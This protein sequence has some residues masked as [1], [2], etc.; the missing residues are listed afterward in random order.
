[1]RNGGP[2]RAPAQVPVTIL[3]F[4]ASGQGGVART[5]LN[6]ASHLADSHPVRIVSLYGGPAGQGY[7]VDPRV[8]LTTL[9]GSQRALGPLAA[10][11]QR[12]PS[13]L[14]PKP[15][16]RRFSRLTDR[17]L[18]RSLAR[19]EPGLLIS[20]RPSLHLAAVQ[21]APR[22]V[23]IIGQ[24]HKNFPVRF[25][26]RRQEQ[27]LRA[28]VP[29]LDAYVVLTRADAQ[30][31]RR[32]MPE[33]GRQHTTLAVIGNALPWSVPAAAA[34]LDTKVIVAAGRLE[35]VKGFDRL[36]RAFALVA[37]DRPDW[38][39]HIYGEGGQRGKLEAL[40]QRLELQAQIRL[41]GH[42]H[43]MRTV[44]AGASVFALSSRAEGFGMV[45]TEA[46]SFGVPLV[47]FDCER[48]PR[49]IVRDRMNGFLVPDGDE[50]SFARAL[51]ALMDDR[52]LRRRLGSEGRRDARR[53]TMEGI[54]AEW[55]ALFATVMAPSNP[56]V[57]S[58]DGSYRVH[59]RP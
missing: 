46:L 14:Q 34:R 43:D 51:A 15:V 23:R 39:L 32:A 54:A 19:M 5:V 18:R 38:Q 58:T 45:L 20:T 49:E 6:L 7:Q 8:Q 16:E 12:R 52:D 59:S 28:A 3:M 22:D 56:H 42:A 48:G 13:R 2:R 47:S 41:P 55:E 33:V 31:Y 50:A 36:V 53:F 27:V 21:W 24:D 29:R 25:A 30:D 40:V 1:M 10:I 35:P 4:D 26:N 37:R 11:L 44:L 57:G 17:L 9:I